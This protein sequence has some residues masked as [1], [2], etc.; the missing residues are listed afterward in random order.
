MFTGKN[1]SSLTRFYAY[2]NGKTT[3]TVNYSY[4]DGNQVVNST[5][6]PW[7]VEDHFIGTD[8]FQVSPGVDTSDP[9]A[10]MS[11]FITSLYRYGNAV[12]NKT[13]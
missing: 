8:A 13:I 11:I 9:N 1:D 3:T 5:K 12:Y 4:W 2:I 10:N 7:A 6:S